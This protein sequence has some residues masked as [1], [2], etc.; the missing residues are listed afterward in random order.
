MKR[1]GGSK[2]GW[3]W[4]VPNGITL[5]RLLLIPILVFLMTPRF[6]S[7]MLPAAFVFAAAAITDYLD[8]FLARRLRVVSDFGKLLD[9]LADK[10]L[11]MAALVMLVA[12][13]SD[14]T[15]ASWVPGWLVVLVLA[16]EMWVTGLRA[17]ASESRVVLAASTTGKV[18]SALQ[19]IAIFFVMLHD[20]WSIQIRSVDI[21]IG[22]FGLNLLLLSVVV[23]YW[24]AVEY[25][26]AVYRERSSSHMLR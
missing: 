7:S 11:V 6:Q 16:R 21:P 13:R 18:K 20:L 10:L 14:L 24:G 9:P 17:L 15:G 19:M 8:G 22:H 4:L 25:S 12:Q 23:S 5:I 3:A 2:I 1:K 26:V